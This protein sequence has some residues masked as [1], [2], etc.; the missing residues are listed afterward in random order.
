MNSLSFKRL[1]NHEVNR[2]WVAALVVSLLLL[3]VVFYASRWVSA[4]S[5]FTDDFSAGT[6]AGWSQTKMSSGASQTVSGGVARFVVP[7]PSGGSVSYSYLVK[8]G[9]TSTVNS[10]IIASQDILVKQVPNGCAEGNG[11]IF[12]FYIC[13]SADLAGDLGNVGV[14]IDGSGVWSLWVG[15]NASYVYI[16][17]TQGSLP[18]SNT[19]YHIVLTVDNSAGLVNLS[20][21]GKTVTS[22]TQHQFTDK[23]HQFSLMSGLGEDW[24]SG[25]VGP[26]EINLDNVRLDVSDAVE[27]VTQAPTTAPTTSNSQGITTNAPTSAPTF[28]STPN[29]T[30]T[31]APPAFS[32]APSQS[33]TPTDMQTSESGF[34]FWVIVPVLVAVAVCFGVLFI[35]KKR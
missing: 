18:T 25:C 24:W 22:A 9:F 31:V 23:T 2:K 3:F 32:S 28:I 11:A 29:P 8:D 19:W 1:G 6:F 12:F 30:V 7:T 5:V 14:G 21:D 15:G 27:P 10:T 4:A 20:V 35:L 26:M 33:A 34:P 16:F 13:D 17:Q